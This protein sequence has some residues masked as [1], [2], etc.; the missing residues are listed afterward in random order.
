LKNNLWYEF[1]GTIECCFSSVPENAIYL[2]ASQS[3]RYNKPS[4]KM[5]TIKIAP[6]KNRPE[7]YNIFFDNSGIGI[8]L[9]DD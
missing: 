8:Q 1:S 9:I 3:A 7:C 5:A 4:I 2:D 6:Y